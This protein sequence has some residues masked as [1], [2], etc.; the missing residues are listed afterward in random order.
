[1]KKGLCTL[2]LVGLV[3]LAACSQAPSQSA[4]KVTIATSLGDIV[5]ELDAQQA[6]VTVDNFLRYVDAGFY[7]GTVFHR[8]IP[9]FMIQGGGFDTA[10]KKKPGFD[11]IRNEAG[12]GLKNLRGT[13]AMARTSVVDSAT[14]EFFIN[15]VDNA[16]LDHQDE[17]ARGFGYAVF[18]RVVKGM[19]VVDSIVKVKTERRNMV[20]AD[21]PVTTV[22]IDSVRRGGD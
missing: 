6:P 7:D 18:G 11:P 8:V 2:V 19:E 5:V 17:T 21:L 15:V 9:N 12:N 16:F 14:S 3:A 4:P 10:L 13:I 20:F 22:T 1:M